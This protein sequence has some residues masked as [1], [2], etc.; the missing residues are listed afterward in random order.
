MRLPRSY[1]IC[2]A[3]WRDSATQAGHAGLRRVLRVPNRYTQVPGGSC[4]GPRRV[5]QILRGSPTRVRMGS[6]PRLRRFYAGFASHAALA[7][8]TCVS[9]ESHASPSHSHSVSRVGPAGPAG[10]VGNVGR[11]STQ[12][13]VVRRK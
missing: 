2:Q 10:P 9:G 7:G 1:N 12:V 5:L 8:L 4:A 3:V 13:A 11:S 6:T